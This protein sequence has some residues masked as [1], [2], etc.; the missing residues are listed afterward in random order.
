MDQCKDYIE[1]EKAYG[2][3][4]LGED[5]DKPKVVKFVREEK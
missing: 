5:A 2:A 3:V 4:P 1:L